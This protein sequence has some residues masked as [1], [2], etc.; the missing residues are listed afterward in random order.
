MLDTINTSKYGSKFSSFFYNFHVSL[1]DP[2]KYSDE[3][4]C[5]S[6]P[7]VANLVWDTRTN[8]CRPDEAFIPNPKRR[9]CKGKKFLGKVADNNKISSL[10][11]NFILARAEKGFKWKIINVFILKDVDDGDYELFLHIDWPVKG[12][13][14]Y[15]QPGPFSEILT[16]AEPKLGL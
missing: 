2:S 10:G 1:G 8:R 14:P 15:F 16:S 11:L 7:Q 12:V 4:S 5:L 3:A 6:A 9:N 13:E